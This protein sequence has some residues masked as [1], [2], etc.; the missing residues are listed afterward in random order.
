MRYGADGGFKSS[1]MLNL[2]SGVAGFHTV[3]TLPEYRIKGFTLTINRVALIY[4][5]KIGYKVRVL[6]ASALGEKVY[7]K[8]G[9]KKYCDIVSYSLNVE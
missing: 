8:L 6:Q 1:L 5:F 4:A 3:S 7:R 2:L 9:F